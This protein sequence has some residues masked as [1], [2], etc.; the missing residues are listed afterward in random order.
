MHVLNTYIESGN[1]PHKESWKKI[2]NTKI[3]CHYEGAWQHHTSILSL[4]PFN[5][6]GSFGEQGSAELGRHCAS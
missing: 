2:I 1:F 3:N 6:I 5:V 4:R